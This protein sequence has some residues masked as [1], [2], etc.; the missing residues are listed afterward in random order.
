MAR[1]CNRSLWPPYLGPSAGLARFARPE[2]A[3]C[4][5]VDGRFVGAT[6]CMVCNVDTALNT[7]SMPFSW[8]GRSVGHAAR[9]GGKGADTFT[10]Q[11]ARADY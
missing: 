2:A 9:T 7:D 4:E 11:L 6:G 5:A 10:R 8:S 3:A 1:T